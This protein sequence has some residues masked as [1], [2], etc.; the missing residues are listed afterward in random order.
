MFNEKRRTLARLVATIC[1][2]AI[3]SGAAIALADTGGLPKT[4]AQPHATGH[5]HPHRLSP[6]AAHKRAALI[7]RKRKEGTRRSSSVHAAAVTTVGPSSVFA[8]QGVA[9]ST[10]PPGA[11]SAASA[12]GLATSAA[13]ITGLQNL[14]AAQTVFGPSTLS[15]SPTATLL[16][17]T[18]QDPI[19]SGV[20]AGVAYPA[21]VVSI[22][23][24]QINAGAQPGVPATSSGLSNAA[25]CKDVGI[26][27]I[28]INRWTELLQSC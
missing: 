15:N 21:W 12:S 10:A 20:T 11:S 22:S 1:V 16:D 14:P 8:D 27:D 9:L 28:Q 3:L 24:P 13:A 25:T 7:A 4:G 6:A 18:E 5:Q 26:Y 19:V 23:G 17:V 2:A